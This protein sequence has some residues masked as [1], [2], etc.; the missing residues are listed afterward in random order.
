MKESALLP[1]TSKLPEH[2]KPGAVTV[3]PKENNPPL[4]RGNSFPSDP[5]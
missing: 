4:Q 1:N 3:G 2:I 5:T